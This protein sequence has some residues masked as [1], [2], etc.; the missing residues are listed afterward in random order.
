[1]WRQNSCVHVNTVQQ[2]SKRTIFSCINNA[3]TTINKSFYV[4]KELDNQETLVSDGMSK[5]CKLKG[6]SRHTL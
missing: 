4:Y 3:S 1:M 6:F 5:S 2:I